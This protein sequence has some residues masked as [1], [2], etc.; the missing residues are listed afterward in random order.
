M[1]TADV[2]AG[3][4]RVN[5]FQQQQQQQQLKSFIAG[6]LPVSRGSDRQ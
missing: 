4:T 3:F 2:A 1:G 6:M 5:P